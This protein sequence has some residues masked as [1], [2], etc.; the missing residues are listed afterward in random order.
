MF[1]FFFFQSIF[2]TNVLNSPQFCFPLWGKQKSASLSGNSPYHCPR[3]P[4]QLE[5]ISVLICNFMTHAKD[6]D[7]PDKRFS[8]PFCI[9]NFKIPHLLKICR[10]YFFLPEPVLS[11]VFCSI[12]QL[13]LVDRGLRLW[14]APDFIVG[15]EFLTFF[16]LVF[17]LL[18]LFGIKERSETEWLYC[19]IFNCKSYFL[20]L[21][22]NFISL[23]HFFKETF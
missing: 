21:K 7:D 22:F 23:I 20:V 1:L 6:T 8:H 5:D 19:I 9:A 12:W 18:F 17:L 3:H 11:L 16:L 13:F 14:L 15:D 2:S 4:L 10:V